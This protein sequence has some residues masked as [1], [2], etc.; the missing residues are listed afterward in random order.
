MNAHLNYSIYLAS[1][2]FAVSQRYNGNR[3][4]AQE[5]LKV[6][7]CFFGHK[8][9]PSSVYEK[10]EEAVE[11]VIV[12]DGVSSFLV[13]NQGQF[14]SMALSALR[15]LKIKYPRINYNVVLA[16]MP[17]EKEMWNPYEY[18]ETMLPEG[19]E[20]VH[21]KYAISWR[22]DWMLRQSNY[23]IAYIH[24][25]WGGAA[26]YV[27]KACRQGKTVINLC[28]NTYFRGGKTE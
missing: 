6:T 22:N 2:Q 13:G 18:G 23:V 17:A 10:L 1:S 28:Q 5:V 20:E 14:D 21:P 15:E 27:Q 9:T 3:R 26:R 25:N 11:K 24:H 8:D 12:E 4:K 19:I 16:Y 7:C